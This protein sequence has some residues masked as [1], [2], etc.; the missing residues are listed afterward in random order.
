MSGWGPTVLLPS[1]IAPTIF[2]SLRCYTD[3]QGNRFSHLVETFLHSLPLLLPSLGNCTTDNYPGVVRS[4]VGRFH[5]SRVFRLDWGNVHLLTLGLT[6]FPFG[7][8][9]LT[10]VSVSKETKKQELV[11]E[12]FKERW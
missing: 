11:L 9:C 4:L 5:V 12:N 10:R 1:I 6:R 8:S 2:S 7:R 3:V